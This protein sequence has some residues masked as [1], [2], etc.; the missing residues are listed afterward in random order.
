MNDSS[1]PSDDDPP[2]RVRLRSVRR[3]DLEW[4]A[5]MEADRDLVGEHNWSGEERS[6]DEVLEALTQRYDGEGFDVRDHGAMVVELVDG[7]PVGSVSWRT[8]RWG[9][10]PRSGCPAFGIALLPEHRGR[11]YGTD[12]QRLLVDHL[13]SMSPEVHRIQSDTAAD[14]RAEQRALEKAGMVREGVVRDAEW[15]D[16]AFHDH[17]LYGM[18]RR[19]WEASADR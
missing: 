2:R 1:A 10:Q 13:F 11:G 19:E 18:L 14:N 17:I 3:G 7:T 16:G 15:R 8:E 9:P 12:A 5:R 6:V 4:M